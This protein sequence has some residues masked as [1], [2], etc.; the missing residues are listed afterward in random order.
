MQKN[1]YFK[2]TVFHVKIIGEIKKITTFHVQKKNQIFVVWKKSDHGENTL[3][4]PLKVKSIGNSLIAQDSAHFTW[5]LNHQPIV[6]SPSCYNILQ[7]FN[8]INAE[9]RDNPFIWRLT[10][11][12]NDYM[13]YTCT[14]NNLCGLSW[15]F[16]I[17]RGKHIVLGLLKTF[18]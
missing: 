12:V 10:Y 14:K 7:H 18:L 6:L 4:S 8:P 3:P 5:L 2:P 1:K 11:F 17:I 13:Q 9:A 15:L 16:Y